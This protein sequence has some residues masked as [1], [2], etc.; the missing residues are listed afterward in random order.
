MSVDP[1]HV[2]ELIMSEKDGF[3]SYLEE[4]AGIKATIRPQP[5]PGAQEAAAATPASKKPQAE[6]PEA[7]Q[8]PTSGQIPGGGGGSG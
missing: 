7:P 5:F 8:E 4:I 2:I 6:V 3:A 1:K